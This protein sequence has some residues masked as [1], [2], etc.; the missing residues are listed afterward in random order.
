MYT[1]KVQRYFVLPLLYVAI[2]FGLLYIQFSGALTVRRSYGDL[3]FTGTLA[4]GEDETSS[5]IIAAR[6]EFNGIAFELSQG[7]PIYILRDGQI[8]RSLIPTRYQTDGNRIVVTL[9]DGSEITFETVDPEGSAMHLIAEP[10]ADWPQ[11]GTLSIPYRVTNRAVTDI[12]SGAT[13]ETIS[14]RYEDRVFF[15]STP[16]RSG[17][18]QIE[19]RVIVPFNGGSQ[20]IRYAEARAGQSNAVEV[21]FAEGQRRVPD[22]TYNTLIQTYIDQAYEGWSD[23]RYNGGSGTWDMRDGTPRFSDEIVLA[24]LAEAWAR[25]EFDAAYAQARRAADLHAAQ[26]GLRSMAFLGNMR[27]VISRVA[28][29]DRTLAAELSQRLT[30]SDP[31]VFQ[32][33]DLLQFA[34]LR[35]NE[36]LYRQVRAAIAEVDTRVVD[37]RSAIGMLW[38]ATV[39]PLPQA[40]L[41]A[42]LARFRDIAEDRVLPAIRQLGDEFYVQ[43]AEGEIDTLYSLLAGIALDRVGQQED[44]ELLQSIGRNL[45]VAVMGLADT[46]GFIPGRVFFSDQGFTGQDGSYGPESIYPL[47]VDNPA[48][49]RL[50]S[51]YDDL[52]A[53][54]YILTAVEFPVIDV[55]ADRHSYVLQYPFE[56]TH[57]ILMQGIDP[58]QSMELFGL[59]WRNDPSFERYSKGRHYEAATESLMIKYNDPTTERNIVI[60]F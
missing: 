8:E 52:G 34:A 22:E 13:A 5:N 28:E 30:D 27:S 18:D 40:E 47:L 36:A 37:L 16:P 41:R 50:I 44:N 56:R 14:V 21:S 11:P 32:Q 43:I 57:Y 42:E 25:N 33:L 35:G 49:P 53:G 29:E 2:V 23:L 20:V 7:E 9:E 39:A 55:S 51:L 48:Y 1:R 15:L 60:E 58:F 45:V 38:Q 17:F 46:R 26:V 59:V 3:R 19:G 12:G 24:Y 10:S 6:A 54:S 4:V 31:T